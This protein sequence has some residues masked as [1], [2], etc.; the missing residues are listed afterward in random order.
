M[1]K[2]VRTL[3]CI[4]ILQYECVVLEAVLVAGS[5]TDRMV[6]LPI[7]MRMH[8]LVCAILLACGL[9]LVHGAQDV[10]Y[11]DNGL[12]WGGICVTSTRQ[13]PINLVPAQYLAAPNAAS[14]QLR[15][16]FGT[17]TNVTVR[18]SMLE[19]LC[20]LHLGQRAVSLSLP[21]LHTAGICHANAFAFCEDSL[22]KVAKLLAIGHSCRVPTRTIKQVLHMCC[23][24]RHAAQQA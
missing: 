13:S 18:F 22:G 16:D 8:M 6:N 12:D 15:F 21:M 4:F 14:P 23:C 2:Q 5:C 1:M 19:S 7:G 17:G 3:V 11:F 20:S 10:S 9:S 24:I